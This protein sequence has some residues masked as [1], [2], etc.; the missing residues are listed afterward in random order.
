MEDSREIQQPFAHVRFSGLG[1]WGVE[2][3][4]PW[5]TMCLDVKCEYGV[6]VCLR[7]ALRLRVRLRWMESFLWEKRGTAELKAQGK[8]SNGKCGRLRM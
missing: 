7:E 8:E 6:L 4:L 2:E 5:R 3:D 1:K